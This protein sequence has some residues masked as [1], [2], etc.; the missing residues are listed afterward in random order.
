MI[1]FNLEIVWKID[2]L[3]KPYDM[4]SAITLDFGSIFGLYTKM[5]SHFFTIPLMKYT[6]RE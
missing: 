2:A 6:N 4:V 5:L 1:E 3:N